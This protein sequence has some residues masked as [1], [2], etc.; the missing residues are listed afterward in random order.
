ME[1]KVCNHKLVLVYSMCLCVRIKWK[2]LCCTKL[3]HC[4]ISW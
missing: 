4:N 3:L 2:V 1:A